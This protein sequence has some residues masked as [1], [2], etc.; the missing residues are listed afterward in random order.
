MGTIFLVN[1]VCGY[2]GSVEITI[3]HIFTSLTHCFLFWKIWTRK[4]REKYNQ[5]GMALL[6]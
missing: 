2:A 6:S 4:I 3:H 5:I 1:M